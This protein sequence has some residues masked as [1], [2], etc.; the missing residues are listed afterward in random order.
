[1]RQPLLENDDEAL[2]DDS[3]FSSVSDFF[4]VKFARFTIGTSFD[5]FASDY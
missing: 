1:M 2:E 5:F 4:L 3:S